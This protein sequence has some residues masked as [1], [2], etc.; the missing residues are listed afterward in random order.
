VFSALSVC[1]VRNHSAKNK[2]LVTTSLHPASPTFFLNLHMATFISSPPPF[3]ST[4]T[5]YFFVYFAQL[6]QDCPVYTKCRKILV[7]GTSVHLQSPHPLC[8]QSQSTYILVH[9]LLGHARFPSAGPPLPHTL[10]HHICLLP[11]PERSSIF[12]RLLFL[13]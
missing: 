1:R 11:L 10:P 13:F 6:L 5:F 8:I 4:P 12:L 7:F 2:N 3:S 9:I